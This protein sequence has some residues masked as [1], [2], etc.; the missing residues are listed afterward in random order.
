M[1]VVN[2]MVENNNNRNLA[3]YFGLSA[4]YWFEMKFIYMS[5]LI[6]S[7]LLCGWTIVMYFYGKKET[8][9]HRIWLFRFV[10]F[11]FFS[12]CD[13][14]CVLIDDLNHSEI[15]HVYIFL[16]SFEQFMVTAFGLK[17]KKSLDLRH[18]KN[19]NFP[20][21]HPA[22]KSII[23]S[24]LKVNNLATRVICVKHN[25]ECLDFRKC[26]ETLFMISL[27]I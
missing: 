10:N 1:K 14:I 25:F 12:S 21:M 13:V 2:E 15:D 4:A 19:V 20:V 27:Y 6:D 3:M 11:N 23:K 16:I 5:N 18:L 17:R 9:H 24:P 26:N 8:L 22:K 7:W